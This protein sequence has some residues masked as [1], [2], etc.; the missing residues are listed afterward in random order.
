M[1]KQQPNFHQVYCLGALGV[2][3][4]PSLETKQGV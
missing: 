1:F 4:Q 2:L 3:R